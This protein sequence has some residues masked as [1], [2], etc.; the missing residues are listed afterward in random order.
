MANDDNPTEHQ[1]S[2]DAGE[3]VTK[4]DADGDM[5][6]RCINRCRWGPDDERGTVNYITPAKIVE[7]AHLI[8]RG[9]VFSL[10]IPFD[11]HGPQTGQGRMNPMLAMR[12]T[13]TDFIS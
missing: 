12:S 5:V 6:T 8:R 4:T 3:L 1:A 11:A 9:H 10:A 2:D 13:G 7:A